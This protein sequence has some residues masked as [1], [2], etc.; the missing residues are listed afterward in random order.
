[1]I[2]QIVIATLVMVFGGAMVCVSFQGT[3]T[4]HWWGHK[5]GAAVFAV[6]VLMMALPLVCSQVK[7]SRAYEAPNPDKRP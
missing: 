4:D 5:T 7:A 2:K 1:M 6:G 3:Y